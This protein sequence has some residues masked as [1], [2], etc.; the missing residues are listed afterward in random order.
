MKSD[1]FWLKNV[2]LNFGVSRGLILN[3]PRP[4]IN[5]VSLCRVYLDGASYRV[6]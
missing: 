3:T 4:F 2:Q 6:P 5:E 1:T